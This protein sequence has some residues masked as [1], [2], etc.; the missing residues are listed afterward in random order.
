MLAVV[1]DLQVSEPGR[2][3]RAEDPFDLDLV[4]S[5]RSWAVHAQ[6]LLSQAARRAV[7]SPSRAAVMA[8]P[9]V[10]TVSFTLNG[11]A[12]Y[13]PARHPQVPRGW[14][15]T[16]AASATE[17]G[18]DRRLAGAVAAAGYVCLKKTGLKAS[19]S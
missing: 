13:V 11:I 1:F 8:V 15:L 6:A 19:W 14:N 10:M 5:S 17:V 9:P 16:G 3:L 12:L 4:Q 7:R 18:A 2:P